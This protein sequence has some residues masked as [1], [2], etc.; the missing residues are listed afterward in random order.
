M[1]IAI[2]GS[3]RVARHIYELLRDKANVE[4]YSLTKVPWADVHI[5]DATI[6]RIEG[7]VLINTLPSRLNEKMLSQALRR[8]MDYMDFATFRD[9]KPEHMAFKEAFDREGLK[10]IANAG[11][12]PGL[13]NLMLSLAG[14][15]KLK[16]YLI[17][18]SAKE[19][20][21]W[22]KEDF[23]YTI[24]DKPVWVENGVIVKKPPYCCVEVR[25]GKPFYAF[26]ADEAVSIAYTLKPKKLE[27]RA[28]GRDIELAKAIY[29]GKKEAEEGE[30]R[31]GLFGIVVEGEKTLRISLRE[32]GNHIAKLTAWMGSLFLERLSEAKGLL[33]PEELSYEVRQSLWEE[34][35]K[36]SL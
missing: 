22:N 19:G 26:Y 2:A 29:E 24:K 7:D 17:E 25:G 23:Y 1:D 31:G 5:G 6:M 10:G 16:L 35:A 18:E 27:V 36:K 9:D 4:V 20:I 8:G 3:G 14:G 30:C 32:E 34:A 33:F 21:C 13:S 12:A 28:G 15:E 11:L